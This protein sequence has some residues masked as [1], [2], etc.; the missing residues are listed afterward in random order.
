MAANPSCY[1]ADITDAAAQ[2]SLTRT[3]N[4]GVAAVLNYSLQLKVCIIAHPLAVAATAAAVTKP[5]TARAA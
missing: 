2:R 1:A 3:G 4:A 5:T